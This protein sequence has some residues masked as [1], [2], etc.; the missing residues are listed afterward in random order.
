MSMID[1]STTDPATNTAGLYE[2]KRIAEIDTTN[3]RLCL[4]SPLGNVYDKSST[5]K[6]HQALKVPNY[7]NVNISGT[8][9]CN[10]WS[11]ATGGILSFRA[12]GQ[13]VLCSGGTISAGSRGCRGGSSSSHRGQGYATYDGVN[14]S[15]DNGGGGGTTHAGAGGHKTAGQA[16]NS[17][18]GFPAGDET[19]T[20]IFMG[21]GGGTSDSSTYG[22]G[23]GG[24]GGGIIMVA[25]PSIELGAW[26]YGDP[27][28]LAAT[29]GHAFAVPLRDYCGGGGAGGSVYLAACR[30]SPGVTEITGDHS[31]LDLRGGDGTWNFQSGSGGRSCLITVPPTDSVQFERVYE[32]LSDGIRYPG[33]Y[34]GG[35]S[36]A[37]PALADLDNDGDLDVPVG[38]ADGTITYWENVGTAQTP[39]WGAPVRGYAGIKVAAFA[40]PAVGDVDGDSLPDIVAG[41]QNGTLTF[42][43]N[44]GDQRQPSFLKITDNF[45]G[46]QVSA[47]SSPTLGDL[48]G[49]GRVDLVCGELV[50]GGLVCKQN[51]GS[52]NWGE[53]IE[54]YA[55][56]WVT[57]D[58]APA[59]VDIDGDGDLDLVVGGYDGTLTLVENTGTRSLAAWDYG[60]ESSWRG[61]SVGAWSVPALGDLN[62]DGRLDM[63]VGNYRGEVSG[64]LDK[65]G[66]FVSAGNSFFFIDVGDRSVPA[67]GDLDGDGDQDMLVG[68]KNGTLVHYENRGSFRVPQWALSVDQYAGIDVGAYAA[69]CLYD[70][71]G[72]GLLDLIIGNQAGT[73]S[74]YRNTGTRQAPVF[75]RQLGYPANPFA[76][77]T[78]G[79]YVAPCLVDVD[80]DTLDD[81]VAG[82]QDASLLWWKNTGT[83]TAPAFTG[84]GTQLPLVVSSYSHPFPARFNPNGRPDLVVGSGDGTLFL[85]TH[86]DSDPTKPWDRTLNFRESIDVGSNAAP[87]LA[88]MDGDGDA[89]LLIG[90]VDGGMVFWR[91]TTP[92]LSIAPRAST[93]F[94]GESLQLEV[95]GIGS[96]PTLTW[97]LVRND[98]GATITLTSPTAFLYTAGSTGGPDKY[99]IVEIRD[100]DST[101]TQPYA[102]A[103]I[104]V[105][106]PEN[107]GMFGKAIICA[108]WKNSGDAVWPATRNL[109]AMAYR[110]LL[111]RGFRAE[112]V[113]L[114][115]PDPTLDTDGD[116]SSNVDRVSTLA[117]L[118]YALQSWAQGTQDLTLYMVDH[119]WQSDGEGRFRLNTGD[120]DVLTASQLAEWLN[121]LQSGAS[122][123]QKVI[124]DCCNSGSFLQSLQPQAGKERIVATACAADQ[125][126]YFVAEGLV[127]F[128]ECFWSTV[129]GD[130]SI[131]QAFRT[132]RDAMERYQSANLDADGNGV[133]TPDTDLADDSPANRAFIGAHQALGGERPQIARVVSNQTLGLGSTT[134]TLWASGVSGSYA[135]SKVWAV[136][137]PPDFQ[138]SGSATDPIVDLPRLDFVYKPA[139]NRWES[140][141]GGFTVFGSY[142]IIIY[143]AD[144]WDAVSLPK[145]VYIHKTD[146]TEKAILLAGN[147]S[148]N[149]STTLESNWFECESAYGAL[150]NRGFGQ[151]T[152]RYLSNQ[153]GNPHVNAPCTSSNLESALAWAGNSTQLTIF[154]TG[155]GDE[156]QVGISTAET[157]T[158][159]SLDGALDTFQAAH[160]VRVI[161]VLDFDHAGSFLD[162]LGHPPNGAQR[163]VVTGSQPGRPAYCLGG[164]TV[165]FGHLFFS[166]IHEGIN[167]FQSM[168]NARNAVR[169]WTDYQQVP[170]VDDNGNGVIDRSDGALARITFIGAA[171]LTGGDELPVIGSVTPETTV[172]RGG[173]VSLWTA[174][175]RDPDGIAGVQATLVPLPP[176]NPNDATTVA[177]NVQS[178]NERWEIRHAFETTGV[179]SVCFAAAD[180]LGN[181][182]SVQTTTVTVEEVAESTPDAF[183]DDD[184]LASA[185]VYRLSDLADYPTT[186]SHTFHDLADEDWIK[187]YVRAGSAYTMRVESPGPNCDT[188]IESYSPDNLVTPVV[189]NDNGSGLPEELSRSFSSS[190]FAYWRITQE[191]PGMYGIGSDYV[192]H[193]VC[194][195]GANNGLASAVGS[196]T[197]WLSWPARL[198]SGQQGFNVYR[199]QTVGGP[200]TRVN[201]A[202]SQATWYF[203]VGLSPNTTYY[204][205]V[206]VVLA[207]GEEAV[208]TDVFSGR[209]TDPPLPSPQ[210]EFAVF[211]SSVTEG[212]RRCSIALVLS[213]PVDDNVMAHYTVE[214][215]AVAGLDYAATLSGYV[216]FAPNQQTATI[217]I[218]ILEDTVID[219]DRNLYLAIDSV[220]NAA[221]GSR[222]GHLLTIVDNDAPVLTAP[223]VYETDDS[224]TSASEY[225]ISSMPDCATTQTH[226]FHAEGDVDWIRFYGVQGCQY[227]LYIRAPGTLCFPVV[228]LY[229]STGATPV[230]GPIAEGSPGQ[231]V[232]AT[233]NCTVSGFYYW[234]VYSFA[235]LLYGDQTTYT[236]E[237]QLTSGANSGLATIISRSRIRCSWDPPPDLSDQGYVLDRMRLGEANWTRVTPAALAA[238]SYDDMGLDANTSYF[239]LVRLH[240]SDGQEPQLWPVFMGTTPVPVTVS[241][242]ALD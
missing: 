5:L 148:F 150:L 172:T 219:G 18:G 109:A 157:L 177:L 93:L 195:N 145:Q 99:D 198:E 220:T 121:G 10:N 25:A 79:H 241:H 163:V 162:E 35:S 36:F 207:S 90:D 129:I 2:T 181:V 116:G 221:R 227:A 31:M 96:T 120:V 41:Q 119:G 176:L 185:T 26:R 14:H 167:V 34:G 38:E 115:S 135:I 202:P 161:V 189:V 52:G 7:R 178:T 142:K 97:S 65:N 137:V 208:W 114:L 53:L 193:V 37:H 136:I 155:R 191:D 55:E 217:D 95:L 111:S 103:F 94:A 169:F 143:A 210:V 59:L 236:A 63:L 30:F 91:N 127:S 69:P 108:G 205:E 125:L 164:G 6:Y 44:V 168:V 238:T 182:S 62:G 118:Q 230:V 231:P 203:D 88:D 146:R 131:A 81:L 159:A 49:D 188:V 113:F 106:A 196:T 66:Q 122:M 211:D 187:L 197:M 67:L 51:L 138:T 4:V 112:D 102:R 228:E 23:V 165:S 225:L 173:V 64:F 132:A 186:Q 152:I 160:P 194:N 190:G 78:P 213:A 17:S 105:L 201:A 124:L 170:G 100:L 71:N 89:D 47:F 70:L 77:L 21:G 1:T 215:T 232:E 85:L 126:T 128:S 73:I 58:S 61:I 199:S 174:G 80:G 8:C 224:K 206:R 72:D 175:V 82:W 54:N 223:D 19:M 133:Y 134:A 200:L 60:Q 235:P 214:G 153:P 110:N 139:E 101:E 130:A 39:E 16:G 192:A 45:A 15:V 212:N 141:Y 68:E 156:N 27:P 226:N 87:V 57:G 233:L 13:V 222:V 48:N 237:I 42:Y 104:N 32:G 11:G 166:G 92:H 229:D 83:T 20:R 158:A 209:T 149:T 3:Q 144:I 50:G 46:I 107:A 171:F 76:N 218:D 28:L 12:T 86:S 123:R 117:N 147:L 179:Y 74:Y 184:S 154:V 9:T 242:W 56:A 151:D 84:S 140:P 29:G 40:T 33:L 216:V 234:K 180:N 24:N 98:S 22:P 183:E 239:Y 240:L 43:K 204:Y 75:T